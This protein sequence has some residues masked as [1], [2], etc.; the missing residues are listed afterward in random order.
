MKVISYTLKKYNCFI[1]LSK[2]SRETCY[3]SEYVLRLQKEYQI[4]QK[5][6]NELT[7]LCKTPLFE[8]SKIVTKSLKTSVFVH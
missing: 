3:Y 1:Y 5:W 4:W 8:A 7:S 2:A 6:K